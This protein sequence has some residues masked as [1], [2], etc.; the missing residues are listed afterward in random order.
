MLLYSA[1]E[2]KPFRVKIIS[3]GGGAAAERLKCIF[4]DNY[5]IRSSIIAIASAEIYE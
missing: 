2:R 4:D 5:W 3:V 1:C